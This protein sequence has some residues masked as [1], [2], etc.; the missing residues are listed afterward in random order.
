MKCNQRETCKADQH[1]NCKS[2]PVT[3]TVLEEAQRIIFGA[4]QDTYGHALDNYTRLAGMFNALFEAKLKSPFSAEDMLINMIMVKLARQVN[5]KHHDNLV[6][7]AGYTG[8]LQ[9]IDR[10]RVRRGR[11]SSN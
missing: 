9:E 8:L 3:E 1:Y 6:D 7:L 10:E 4:R 2:Q 11:K 5:S